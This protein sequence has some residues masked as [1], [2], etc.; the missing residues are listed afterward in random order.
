MAKIIADVYVAKEDK[1]S[2][3]EITFSYDL[4]KSL[5]N[6]VGDVIPGERKKEIGKIVYM[7][8]EE[9]KDFLLYQNSKAR[10]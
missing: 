6:L 10:E 5:Q 2:N 7:S 3:K 8:L 1:Y 9:I 4:K